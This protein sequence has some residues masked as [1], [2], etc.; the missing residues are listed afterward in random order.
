MFLNFSEVVKRSRSLRGKERNLR[1]YPKLNFMKLY[2]RFNE[3]KLLPFELPHIRREWKEIIQMLDGINKLIWD[4][5]RFRRST[6]N[7]ND[8]RIER[9][10]NLIF[11]LST[12]VREL[13]EKFLAVIS[14]EE[15]VW[16]NYVLNLA[17]GVLKKE[18]GIALSKDDIRELMPSAGLS[19]LKIA[20]RQMFTPVEQ[21]LESIESDL[22]DGVVDDAKFR[23]LEDAMLLKMLPWFYRMFERSI[24]VV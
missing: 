5:A 15:I 10:Y 24:E 12:K 23:Q 7:W 17:F 13:H 4:I 18:L 14:E 9:M 8:R 1:L 22:A 16:R 19:A 6:S 2:Y 21:L 3:H 11:E 20:I